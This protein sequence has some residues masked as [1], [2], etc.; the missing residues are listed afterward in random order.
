[1]SGGFHRKDV[2]IFASPPDDEWVEHPSEDS[3]FLVSQE[4]RNNSGSWRNNPEQLSLPRAKRYGNNR[5]DSQQEGG[6]DSPNRTESAFYRGEENGMRKRSS[7]PSRVQKKEGSNASK[8]SDSPRGEENMMKRRSDSPHRRSNRH[9]S[10]VNMRSSNKHGDSEVYRRSYSPT[11]RYD[12]KDMVNEPFMKSTTKNLEES[13]PGEKSPLSIENFRKK[14]DKGNMS[15]V[16]VVAP[17]RRTSEEGRGKVT[18]DSFWD[19]EDS[20]KR[21]IPGYKDKLKLSDENLLSNKEYN[22]KVKRFDENHQMSA[23]EKKLRE[24]TM[25]LSPQERFLDAKSKFLMLEKERL[26]EQDK[27]AQNLE[28]KRGMQDEAPISPEIIRNRPSWNRSAE[29]SKKLKNQKAELVRRN[30]FFE[31]DNTDKYYDKEPRGNSI[32]R[33]KDSIHDQELQIRRLSRSDSRSRFFSQ[34]R[35]TGDL[36]YEIRYRSDSPRKYRDDS[37]GPRRMRM[38]DDRDYP[39]HRRHSRG[40]Y[41]RDWER[42]RERYASPSRSPKYSGSN[43]RRQTPSDDENYLDDDRYR[44]DR[45]RYVEKERSFSNGRGTPPRTRCDDEED[46]RRRRCV[47]DENDVTDLPTHFKSPGKNRPVVREDKAVPYDKNKKSKYEMMEKEKRLSSNALAKEFKRRSYQEKIEPDKRISYIER[48]YDG[49]RYCDEYSDEI[50]YP[51]KADVRRQNQYNLANMEFKRNS[52]ELAKEFNRR[53]RGYSYESDEDCR[54]PRSG[55]SDHKERER[56]PVVERESSRLPHHQVDDCHPES[57]KLSRMNSDDHERFI[58]PPRMVQLQ[59]D[60][61]PARYRHSFVDNP[62]G[63]A[64]MAPGRGHEMLH[65]TNS[66]VSSN[67]V[68]IAA[69]HPY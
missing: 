46:L 38:R 67:R 7:S 54:K 1:M 68:G 56:Y 58:E 57:G 2:E 64:V 27:N 35:L 40:D 62:P 47:S 6:G 23:K 41:D 34:E 32:D 59:V 14:N 17:R 50:G 8:R 39:N 19:E 30:S 13:I 43:N 33:L 45:K 21:R 36:D 16:G 48:D 61:M 29:D 18:N 28:K 69:V 60:R 12:R 44:H 3:L 15:P 9:I 55:Y 52:H 10:P 65:R 20:Y 51:E 37:D 63:L 5:L 11:G 26:K 66:S 22:Q 42:D 49:G 4:G 24:N 31:I 53:S 25:K